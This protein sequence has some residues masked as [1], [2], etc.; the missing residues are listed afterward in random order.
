MENRLKALENKCITVFAKFKEARIE[1]KHGNMIEFNEIRELNSGELIIDH[2]WLDTRYFDL[3]LIEQLKP[4]DIVVF[5]GIVGSYTRDREFCFE[6]DYTLVCIKYK[7]AI[8]KIEDNGKYNLLSDMNSNIR[9][10]T[11]TNINDAINK[12]VTR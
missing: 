7:D 2:L 8:V 10:E 5:S 12:I 9:V 11:Y 3:N 6:K 4:E 1:K